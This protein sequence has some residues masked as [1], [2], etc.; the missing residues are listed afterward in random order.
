MLKQAITQRQSVRRQGWQREKHAHIWSKCPA[1]HK[2][3]EEPSLWR[4]CHQRLIG[5]LLLWV[6]LIAFQK[7]Q[8]FIALTQAVLQTFTRRRLDNYSHLWLIISDWSNKKVCLFFQHAAYW[9]HTLYGKFQLMTI[10]QLSFWTQCRQPFIYL[11]MLIFAVF[12]T[13]L[14]NIVTV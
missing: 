7:T 8:V 4:S 9:A 13:G 11:F 5:S 12:L 6:S 14:L 1:C 3:L 10:L 2:K